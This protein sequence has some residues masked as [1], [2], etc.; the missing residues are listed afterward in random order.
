MELAYESATI[1]SKCEKS[2]FK[3]GNMKEK[4]KLLKVLDIDTFETKLGTLESL[5]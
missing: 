1:K 3:S 4:N 2:C 5:F